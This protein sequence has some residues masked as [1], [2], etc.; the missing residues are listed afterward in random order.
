MS[1][2]R[3]SPYRRDDSLPN[4]KA[5]L[6]RALVG[7]LCFYAAVIFF[8]C[9]W[10]RPELFGLAGGIDIPSE[11]SDPAVRAWHDARALQKNKAHAEEQAEGRVGRSNADNAPRLVPTDAKDN[12]P[13]L[14]EA[15]GA[16]PPARDLPPSIVWSGTLDVSRCWTPQG[17]EVPA[18]QC[19]EL[20]ALRDALA[21]RLHVIAGCRDAVVNKMS[22]GRLALGIEV[23]YSRAALSI[24]KALGTDIEKAEAI[25]SCVEEKLEGLGPID[26]FAKYSRYMMSLTVVFPSPVELAKKLEQGDLLPDGAGES[27]YK[28]VRVI[29]KNVRVRTEPMDGDV[30]DAVSAPEEVL[31]L[32]NRGDDWCLVVTAEKIKGWM[33]CWGL[34]ILGGD[35]LK[36]E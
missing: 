12:M 15:K 2:L 33:V 28:A 14:P 10:L 18:S 9:A 7:A 35:Q 6:K 5:S 36:L 4:P 13:K 19:D 34:D 29:R 22:Y 17:V 23:D 25:V 11:I 31:L 3:Y 1:K 30:I 20:P 21:Q 8:A 26:K 24:W 27:R 32:K 16:L